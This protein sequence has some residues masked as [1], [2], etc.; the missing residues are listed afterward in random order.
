MK[1]DPLTP[2]ATS[3]ADPDHARKFAVILSIQPDDSQP[4]TQFSAEQRKAYEWAIKWLHDF[5]LHRMREPGFSDEVL[6]RLSDFHG[7]QMNEHFREKAAVQPS[8][9]TKP[10]DLPALP[11][12]HPEDAAKVAAILS[13]RPDPSQPLSQ[14]SA[15][16]RAAY[17]WAVQRAH[18]AR[19]SGRSNLRFSAEALGRL[20]DF[21]Q[22]QRAHY[23]RL[24][25]AEVAAS[26]LSF[27]DPT[28]EWSQRVLIGMKRMD[29]DPEFRD[30]V[31]RRIT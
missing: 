3:A 27:T 24:N 6:A 15:E 14:F 18:E 5:N 20:A 9:G 31:S 22:T 1:M 21:H 29:T 16:Q 8:T 30:F 10:L 4:L 13:I 17:R 19:M 11:P 26:G 2:A 25:T 7:V 28:D 23:H 12:E